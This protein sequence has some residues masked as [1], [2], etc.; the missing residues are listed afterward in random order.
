MSIQA[1]DCVVLVYYYYYY[2]SDYLVSREWGLRR[3][4]FVSESQQGMMWRVFRV[5]FWRWEGTW[6]Q[7]VC[8]WW[9]RNA[10]PQLA[11]RPLRSRMTKT[12]SL[13]AKSNQRAGLTKCLGTTLSKNSALGGSE[14][15]STT[16]NFKLDTVFH[17]LPLLGITACPLSTYVGFVESHD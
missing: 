6:T 13:I 15:P 17:T 7:P 4:R 16:N 12:Q 9:P 8:L 2:Y 10:E 5:G 3:P 1:L 11:L 14:P